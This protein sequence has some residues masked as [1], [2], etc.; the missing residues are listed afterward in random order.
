MQQINYFLHLFKFYLENLKAYPIRLLTNL[1]WLFFGFVPQFFL[2]YVISK[3]SN[4]LPYTLTEI[5]L[6]FLFVWGLYYNVG[7][8]NKHFK[9]ISTGEVS[10][11]IIKPIS[12]TNMY[13]YNFFAEITISKIVNIV[14]ITIAGAILVGIV[15]TLFGIL[16][17]IFGLTIGC[18]F[19]VILFFT[20]FWL[21]NNWG[22]KFSIDMF[23]TFC[24]GLWIPLDLFPAFWQ[25][26]VN[27]LPFKLMFF[28]PT[29]IFLGQLEITIWI[30][31]QYIIWF[32]ILYI[33]A[34]L[35][36]YYGLK[37]YEQL[38]G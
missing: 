31:L 32:I 28:Y 34:R 4:N 23:I 30:I 14:L 3:T 10:T 27:Y 35:L 5:I 18:I 20:M 21:R 36:E 12:L 19:Y 26:V 13:F 22:I 33:I 38:G 2:W 15:N 24:S 16:F 17:F 29:K 7:S 9:V 37:G 1:F 11:S 8:I 25:N 6:Y